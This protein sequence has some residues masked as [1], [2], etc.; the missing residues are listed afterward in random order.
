MFHYLFPTDIEPSDMANAT[1]PPVERL[2]VEYPAGFNP[3]K[4]RTSRLEHAQVPQIRKEIVFP[5][6]LDPTD[7][8]NLNA[9]EAEKNAPWSKAKN[10]L[11][12]SLNFKKIST[13]SK[14]LDMAT[15]KKSHS[16]ASD[17]LPPVYSTEE[18]NESIHSKSASASRSQLLLAVSD[19][20]IEPLPA[21]PAAPTN[22][23]HHNKESTGINSDKI[24]SR[25]L[26]NQ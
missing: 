24:F 10:K 22:I 2:A 13:S 5:K 3:G 1:E 26:I 20:T 8:A 6:T 25:K 23:L 9:A 7:V 18:L 19:L 15:H 11:L 12:H 21:V 16:T 14:H 4:R 17:D